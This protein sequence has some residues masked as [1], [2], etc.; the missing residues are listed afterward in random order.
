MTDNEGFAISYLHSVN[1]S[2][3]K[4]FFEVRQG[5]IVLSALEFETFG[6]G[7]P[8]ELAPGQQLIH[9]PGGTMRIENFDRIIYDL[10]FFIRGHKLHI[11]GETFALEP[12]SLHF[13]LIQE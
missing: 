12:G 9:L 6:A 10:H 4:E 2:Y 11:N 5:K 1:Q 8:T 13:S 7:M 3:V